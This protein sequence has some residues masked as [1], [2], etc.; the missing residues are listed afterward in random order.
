MTDPILL[1]GVIGTLAGI[2][3]AATGIYA[4]QRQKVKD[5]EVEAA[6]AAAA[7][8]AS[9]TALNSALDREIKRLNAEIE[10]ARVRIT[11]LENELHI[12]RRT[13]RGGDPG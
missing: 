8:V 3:G 6:T 10:A 9:W 5:R 13:M 4:G 7:G 11:E 2:I 1:T 12:L